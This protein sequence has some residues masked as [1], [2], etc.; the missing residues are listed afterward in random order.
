MSKMSLWYRAFH[1]SS[2]S[3]VQPYDAFSMR[4][5]GATEGE[6]ATDMGYMSFPLSSYSCISPCADRRR[7]DAALRRRCA[8]SPSCEVMGG[9]ILY[10]EPFLTAWAH[11]S[12]ASDRHSHSARSETHRVDGVLSDAV[13]AKERTRNQHRAPVDLVFHS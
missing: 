12:G 4:I 2:S 13:D 1:P 8:S 3:S 7:R 6:A 9:L 11:G 5:C 10:F